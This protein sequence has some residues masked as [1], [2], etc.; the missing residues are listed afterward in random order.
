MKIRWNVKEVEGQEEESLK[1]DTDGEMPRIGDVVFFTNYDNYRN[2]QHVKY[3]VVDAY[4]SV[5]KSSRS[6][7]QVKPY[8]KGDND[9]ER[10]ASV[11]DHFRVDGYGHSSLN[12]RERKWE[13]TSQE[14]YVTLEP[15]SRD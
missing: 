10:T 7:E 1:F 2:E 15:Y 9:Y 14:G 8:I 12:I 11:E 5:S 4:H 13:I 3:R 6:V